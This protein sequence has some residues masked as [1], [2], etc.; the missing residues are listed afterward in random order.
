[1]SAPL[2]LDLRSDDRTSIDTLIAEADAAM[3]EA[4][5]AGRVAWPALGDDF[6]R[7][8]LGSPG[9]ALYFLVVQRVEGVAESNLFLMSK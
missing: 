6:R 9:L 4:K 2:G 1:M 8:G 5:R 3:Y 7:A